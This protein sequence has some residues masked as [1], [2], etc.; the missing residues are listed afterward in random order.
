MNKEIIDIEGNRAD[1]QARQTMHLYKEGTFIRAYNWSAWLCCRY[2]NAFKVNKRLY[3][4]IDKPV[5]YI[6][7]PETS[8]S[9]WVKSPQLLEQLD[10]KHFVLVLD[11]AP[12][13]LDESEMNA[14]YESWYN[15]IPLIEQKPK[16]EKRSAGEV[17]ASA[18]PS[19]LTGVMQKI[20][21]YPLENKSPIDCMLF[22]SEIKKELSSLI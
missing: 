3:N 7:F 20:I 17:Y 10:E 9:K 18:H 14:L 5:A 16:N 15:D 2:L 19:S 21:A 8:I 22:L 12:E 6:G 4:G 1:A 13:D 11:M